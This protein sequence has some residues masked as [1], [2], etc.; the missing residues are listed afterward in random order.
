MSL[1]SYSYMEIIGLTKTIGC[2]CERKG[3][4]ELKFKNRPLTQE[5]NEKCRYLLAVKITAQ[6]REYSN[7]KSCEVSL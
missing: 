6:T 1:S 2:T 4:R 7:S 3:T 5:I